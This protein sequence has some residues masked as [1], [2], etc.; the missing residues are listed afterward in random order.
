MVALALLGAGFGNECHDAAADARLSVAVSR[1]L[2][3][4][5]TEP[6]R[7][8][9]HFEPRD[10]STER[11]TAA[12]AEAVAAL[13]PRARERRQRMAWPDAVT[14]HLPADARDLPLD[15]GR[16]AACLDT[17]AELVHRSRW[18]NAASFRATPAAVRR[19]ASLDGVRAVTLVG[20]S[21]PA[22]IPRP[23]GA[24]TDLGRR[25][26]APA[27]KSDPIDYG[28]NAATMAQINVPAVH[29]LGLSGA[30]V[31]VGMLDTGFRTTHEAFAGLPVLDAWDFVDG[32]AV[33]DE[34]AGDPTGTRNHGTMTLSSVAAHMPGQLVAPAYGASVLLART[35][36]L[37]QETQVEED[38]WVAGL[39]WAEARGADIISSSLGYVDWYDYADLDGN[40]AV[41]TIAADLAAA[42]GLV[43][44][45]AA[46]NDRGTTG[47]LIA[48]G[49]A[50]SVVTVGAVDDAGV[51]AWFSS[52]GPTADG[53]IKPDVAARGVSNPLVDPNDDTNYVAASGTSFATP[54]TSGVVALMLE[55]V[56]SLTPL[57]VI[58]ALRATASQSAAPDNDQGWGI[59]DALAAVTW[60]GPVITHTPVPEFTDS[61]GPIT[62]QGLITD[63]EGLDPGQLLLHYRVG[64]GAWQQ[65]P[66][67][68]LAIPEAY[69]ADIPGQSG[70][71]QVD[72]Y[73]AAGSV[74][75]VATTYPYAGAAAPLHYTVTGPAASGPGALPPISVL[76]SAVPNPFN[77]RTTL[78]FTLARSGQV[79][80]AIHD[81]RGA[82]VRTLLAEWREAGPHTVAWDGRDDRGRAVA[83]GTY[84]TR[85]TAPDV[86]RHG[87]MQLVR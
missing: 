46:G 1:A 15:A 74:G 61:T 22:A 82:L 47:H 30:G 53:R 20:G 27:V 84:L 56:P 51:T 7:V 36:H 38:H 5:P 62:I 2:G 50:D 11:T 33:V 57:Q 69:S 19:L 23:V 25:P 68:P 49:D 81:V 85:L 63:R 86:V 3:G 18:L 43:V 10:W 39:E 72:Y 28:A 8:W 17:G 35:E 83:G 6:L 21:R 34:E 71:V 87:K 77:P 26:A 12:L 60:F 78:G 73:L 14:D 9:V 29:D 58:A 54:V 64:G 59:V 24:T 70:P 79:R 16:L 32:D 42:R 80:L 37:T 4:A 41:T 31:V 13:S 76:Q 48:P 45:T 40:T 65:V 75:G 44:V 55:R 67:A 66:L 52:P